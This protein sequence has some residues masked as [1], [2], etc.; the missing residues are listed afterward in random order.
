MIEAPKRI[1]VKVHKCQELDR[2]TAYI[3]ADLVDKLI[4]EQLVY[5]KLL[6]EEIESMIGIAHSH[7]WRS[8]RH[9]S[10]KDCRQ[11]LDNLIRE[12]RG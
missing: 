4:D 3:R 12:V 11:R 8:T 5:Q 9:D 10:G 7:G 6:V 1:T 2:P